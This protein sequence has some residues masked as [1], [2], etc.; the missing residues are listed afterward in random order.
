MRWG[1]ASAVVAFVVLFA[2]AGI[3]EWQISR[4]AKR[5]YQTAC[6]RSNDVRAGVVT[7]VEGTL[8]RSER[9]N[10]AVV[11]SK[12]ATPAEKRAAQQNLDGIDAVR[13]QAHTAFAAQD[14][15]YPPPGDP[16]RLT[17]TTVA[18]TARP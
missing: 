7:F 12:T 4:N 2:F 5:A 3:S 10:T 9:F 16:P 17:T 1:K 11:A 6:M 13:R 18:E 15:T 8:Q 14:C